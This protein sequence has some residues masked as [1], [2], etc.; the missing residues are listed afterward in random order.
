M[1]ISSPFAD[2]SRQCIEKRPDPHNMPEPHNSS[3]DDSDA[4]SD[5]L[6]QYGTR[7]HKRKRKVRCGVICIRIYRHSALAESK[8]QLTTHK[9]RP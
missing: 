8:S 3:D 7:K 2:V 4:S 1:A 5:N 6:G 9:S